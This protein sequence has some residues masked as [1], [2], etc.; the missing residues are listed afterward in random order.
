MGNRLLTRWERLFRVAKT[1]AKGNVSGDPGVLNK[2]GLKYVLLGSLKGEKSDKF[3]DT[4]VRILKRK[5]C[6]GF[7]HSPVATD[8]NITPSTSSCRLFRCLQTS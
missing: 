5:R 2:S 1:Y 7:A 6:L 8:V 4:Q 3:T